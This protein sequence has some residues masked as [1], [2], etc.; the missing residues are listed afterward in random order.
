MAVSWT[1]LPPLKKI[2]ENPSISDDK[3]DIKN[4]SGLTLLNQ[5]ITSGSEDYPRSV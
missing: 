5:V 2:C 1:F 4:G 3:Q